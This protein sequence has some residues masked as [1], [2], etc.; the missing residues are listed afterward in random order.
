MFVKMGFLQFVFS[1]IESSFR[2]FVKAIDSNA[3]AG[4]T[5][6]FKNIYAFLLT[7]FGLQKWE[8]LLDLL[9]GVRN[10][11]HN[12][13]V[14]FHRSGKNETVTYKGVNYSFVVGRA[15]DIIDWAFL[16]SM[17]K[18]IDSMLQEVVNYSELIA[19]PAII[20]PFSVR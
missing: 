20:D 6:E 2:L 17:M 12:N 7:R 1:S 11:I 15:V 14:Y 3:C 18:D 4:G 9:R 13:G 19:V 10:T 8:P 5:A 16:I